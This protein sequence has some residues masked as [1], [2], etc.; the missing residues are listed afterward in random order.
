MHRVADVVMMG[1]LTLAS[2]NDWRRKVVS[3]NLLVVMNLAAIC[4]VIACRDSIGE[5]LLGVLIGLG[6][7]LISK[8]S[9]EQIGYGDSWLILILGIY[10]GGKRIL[11]LLF[12]ASLGAALFSLI[13]CLLYHWNRKFSIPFIPFL[14]VAFL[15]VILL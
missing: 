7:F 13:F 1:L 9:Q 10:A 15:G 8:W 5:V 11:L 3:V 12:V 14:T 6:F 2:W 4:K